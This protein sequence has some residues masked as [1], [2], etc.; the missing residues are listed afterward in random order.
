[1]NINR[2]KSMLNENY[3]NTSSNLSSACRTLAVAILGAML[4]V[5]WSSK[6]D[7]QLNPMMLLPLGIYFCVD[8]LQYLMCLILIHRYD[9]QHYNLMISD[10]TLGKKMLRL[11]KVSLY[12]VYCKV[13]TLVVAVCFLIEMF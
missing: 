11:Q 10:D 9:R 1:M 3:Y 12:I 8:I 2:L 13:T 5:V 6:G 7:T 4:G